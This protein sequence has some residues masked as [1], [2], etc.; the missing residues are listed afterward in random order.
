MDIEC[1]Y[2]KY[3]PAFLMAR[4]RGA[5]DVKVLNSYW[6]GFSTYPWYSGVRPDIMA[7]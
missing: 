6:S 2:N 1:V 3:R 5:T 4:K 7:S